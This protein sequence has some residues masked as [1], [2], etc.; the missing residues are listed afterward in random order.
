MKKTQRTK[1]L[2]GLVGI[3]AAALALTTGC[4]VA[5]IPGGPQG[6]AAAPTAT[7]AVKLSSLPVQK[8]SEF[9]GWN[10]MDGEANFKWSDAD[11]A[12][13]EKN[14][15]AILKVLIEDHPEFTVEGFKPTPKVWANEVAPALQP[16]TVSSAWPRFTRSWTKEVPLE[17][18]AFRDDEAVVFE[19][20]VVLTSRPEILQ[21]ATFPAYEVI[22]SWNSKSGEQC[23]A[24]DKPYE[25]S[26]QVLSITTRP[27]GNSFASAYPLLSGMY[28]LTVHCKEGGKLKSAMMTTIQMKKENGECL[29]SGGN[30]LAGYAF[31]TAELEK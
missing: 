7:P 20:N 17:N 31:G 9:E 6:A 30:I 16:L 15:K 26:P 18:G 3:L 19:P 25:V 21:S 2:A 27:E 14:G 13:M 23:S 22:R 8:D 12:S 24:S 1:Q 28:D 4:Q 29:L 11:K 5:P 10:S